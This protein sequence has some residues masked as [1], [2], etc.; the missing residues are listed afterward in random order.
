[1]KLDWGH[2]EVRG[3]PFEG[4][5]LPQEI[6]HNLRVLHATARFRK[7]LA[8]LSTSRL[9]LLPGLRSR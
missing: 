9:I 3:L 6:V 4:N 5:I 8:T 2:S 1:M 7:D